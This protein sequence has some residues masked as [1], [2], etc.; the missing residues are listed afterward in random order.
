MSNKLPFVSS[1]IPKDLRT[2][3]DRVRETLFGTGIERAVTVRDLLNA[4]I[5][6]VTPG[7]TITSPSGVIGTPPAMTNLAASG[8]LANIILTWDPPVYNGHS[9]AEIWSAST[10]DLGE[11][12]LLSLAP[13]SIYSDNVGSSATRYY[14][15]RF[16]NVLGV[17]GPF[18]STEGT[19]GQTGTD[20][21]YVLSL[22]A[23][24]I[25]ESELA[26]AL[27]DRIDLIDAPST[28]VG[29]V[30]EKFAF[31]QGQIDS[32]TSIPAYDNGTTYAIDD[33]VTYNDAIYRA[34]AATTGNL[35]TDTDYWEKIGDYTSIAATVAAHTTELDVLNSGIDAEVTERE[36]LATQ[37]RGDYTGTDITQ[38]AAGL[39][40]SERQA[41][42]SADGALSTSISTVS[43]TAAGKNKI[44]R[45]TTPPSSPQLNDI[46]VDT[47]IS[48]VESTYFDS[49]YSVPKYK[50]F[51]WDGS[52][53]ID[54]TDQDIRDN[55]AAVTQ[56]IVARANADEA[57]ATQITTVAAGIDQN[58]AA[59][60]A[61][62]TA[63]TT[64][65]TALATDITTLASTVNTNNSTLTAAIQTEATT[66]ASADTALASNI[67]TLQTTVGTNTTSIQTNQQSID[68]V[69]G[70]YTVRMDNNG[71]LSGFGLISEFTQDPPEVPTSTFLVNVDK[72]AVAI[73]PSSLSNW[74]SLTSYAANRIVS[75]PGNTDKMLVCKVAGTSG[76]STPSISGAIGS[77]V[78][79]ANVVWQIA[80]RVPFYALTN[81]TTINGQSIAPGVY[82]DGASIA[83][84]T[85]GNA[86]IANAAIDNAKISD[87]SASKI[88]AG[89]IS[90]GEYVQSSNYIADNQG[91]RINGDGNVEF[92]NAVVRG[93]VFATDGEFTGTVKAASTILG[94][95]AESF[96]V[97]TGLFAGYVGSTYVFRVGDPDGTNLRWNGSSVS[98][99]NINISNGTLTAGLIKS[100]DG[101]FEISLTNK[102]I[103]IIS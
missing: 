89:S 47:K 39:I 100:T 96:Y 20:P 19:L 95:S 9:H 81:T 31:L 72:F 36:T 74:Q 103:R 65:D 18:N 58:T 29:S 6:G 102:Y 93:T 43:A 17:A 64:A 73:P 71:F 15:G 79:D 12:V 62:T 35:P 57:L 40:Y 21:A 10:N 67:T 46:W 16:V 5:I 11:A 52:E 97:G 33:V 25:T 91:W 90:V 8:A 76:V 53:W 75:I 59:I 99:T 50:Q 27:S 13:G 56:E 98:T 4:G 41:R 28:V 87:L 49:D 45:Q 55:F 61:E 44:Y 78:N 85:I 88:T 83:N 14:W 1:Q 77:L 42:V 86:Q 38:I 26:D 92:S 34:I 23:G 70:L 2:F 82:I 54:I 37:L 24:E 68:G 66:R 80:S 32:I 101:D 51:Q 69:K 30:N 84:A 63:R 48:Y 94:G 60:I 3:L 22:L 7:G